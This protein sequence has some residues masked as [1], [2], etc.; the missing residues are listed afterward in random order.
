MQSQI[1]NDGNVY[2]LSV[3]EAGRRLSLGRTTIFE[4][5]ATGQLKRVKIGRKT[6]ITAKSLKRLARHGDERQ[7]EQANGAL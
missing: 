3:A 2:L 6:L 5:I 7:T 1:M 4:L